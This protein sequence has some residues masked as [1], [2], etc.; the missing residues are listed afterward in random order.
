MNRSL[1]LVVVF[2]V[3]GVGLPRASA[4][5]QD[6]RTQAEFR[7]QVAL[8]AL[9]DGNFP[10]ALRELDAAAQMEPKMPSFSTT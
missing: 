2:V 5:N 8:A 1:A 6:A 10:I 7:Y 3:I 9:K 4:Q